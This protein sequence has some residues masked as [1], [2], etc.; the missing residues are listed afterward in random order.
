MTDTIRA[1]SD[2]DFLALLPR[3]AGYTA[4]NSVVCALFRG[5]A[6]VAAFRL[7]LPGR[8][9]AAGH[10]AI[11]EFI[12]ATARRIPGVDRVA[13]V[14]YTD[15]S[16]EEQHGIPWPTLGRDVERRIGR[17]GLDI[18]GLFC[19]ASDGWGSYAE[20]PRPR[21][22]PLE[23]IRESPVHTEVAPLPRAELPEVGDLERRAFAGHLR[24][25]D[26]MVRPAELVEACLE[27]RPDTRHRATL[28]LLVQSP[29]VRD[30]AMLQ[31]AF[32]ELV[33]SVV[34]ER[35]RRL[36][37][38]RR[39]RGG[40]MD[41]AVLEE[42][43]AGRLDLDDEIDGLMLGRGRIRPDAG[44]IRRGIEVLRFTVACLEDVDR[45]AP[46]CMLIWLCWALGLGSAASG[47]LDLARRI[48]PDYGMT[49]LLGI[50]IT[51]SPFPEWAL[52]EGDV[53]ND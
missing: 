43:R 39:V 20:R 12:L 42:V 17:G 23:E 44:R 5:R 3:I 11:A 33:G 28:A 22:H 26:E 32:G 37:A 52:P 21:R 10:R 46:L 29:A 1:A 18:A 34:A 8:G 16:F 31:I 6:S 53:A 36:E 47:W 4:R 45:P 51:G 25:L 50:L 9:R 7:D 35:N 15:D 49:R 19:V 13:L 38:R 30:E 2:A 14:V 48:D 40:S 24:T 41:D 27:A